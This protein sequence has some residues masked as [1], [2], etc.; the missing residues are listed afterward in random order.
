MKRA[1]TQG[2]KYDCAWVWIA[3]HRLVSVVLLMVASRLPECTV[4]FGSVN[5][6]VTGPFS[7]GG[8]DFR[9]CLS[10]GV[11]N[12]QNKRATT[13]GVERFDGCPHGLW[14][15]IKRC[16]IRDTV[17]MFQGGNCVLGWE[18]KNKLWM[19]MQCG[20]MWNGNQG[21]PDELKVLPLVHG[22]TLNIPPQKPNLQI[23]INSVPESNAY[24]WPWQHSDR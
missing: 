5:A 22:D 19:G 2:P 12:K 1:R 17:H 13:T 18:D 7:C 20:G 21:D 4:L 15:D 11:T 3:C 10:S 24:S 23:H 16:M 6:G 9:G 8:G 14:R